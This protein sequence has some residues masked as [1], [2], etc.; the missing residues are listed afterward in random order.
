MFFEIGLDGV[1][2]EGAV[3]RVLVSLSAERPE[4]LV[5][6]VGYRGEESRHIKTAKRSQFFGVFRGVD[7]L[8]G[9]DVSSASAPL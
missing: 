9:Q 7:W 2:I 6:L 4:V 8:D 1:E 5:R 3:A